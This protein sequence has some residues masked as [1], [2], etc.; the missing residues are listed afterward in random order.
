MILIDAVW[1]V[2]VYAAN[3]RLYMSLGISI[4]PFGGENSMVL[5]ICG[6]LQKQLYHFLNLAHFFYSICQSVPFSI[7]GRFQCR[8]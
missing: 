5:N 7:F 8:L 6:R 3:E 4:V 2:R 1:T